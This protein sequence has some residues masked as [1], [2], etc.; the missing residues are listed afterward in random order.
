MKTLLIFAHP[1]IQHSRTNRLMFAAAQRVADITVV[2]LYA[3]YPRHEI[4]IDR[5]QERLA[6]HDILV[7]QFPL[8]WYSPPSLIKE[9]Q[10]LVLEHGFAYGEKG[11]ALRGKPWLCAVTAGASAEAYDQG[12]HRFSLRQLLSPVEATAALCGMPFLSPY[13]LFGA[14]G[15]E[16]ARRKAHIEGFVTLLEA[17]RDDRFDIAAGQHADILTNANLS[18][19]LMGQAS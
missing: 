3:D 7:L 19:A 5:E 2:D 9:W 6:A 12:R 15:V 17:L 1:A 11:T 18:S 14:A 4:D 10:D 8:F 16:D 13:V